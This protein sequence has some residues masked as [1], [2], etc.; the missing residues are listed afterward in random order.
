MVFLSVVRVDDV[1]DVGLS[2]VPDLLFFSEPIVDPDLVD[3]LSSVTLERPA[4]GPVLGLV[5]EAAGPVVAGALEVGADL[6]AGVDLVVDLTFGWT[7]LTATSLAAD[8]GLAPIEDFLGEFVVGP[9]LDPL[10]SVLTFSSF[11]SFSFLSRG[12]GDLSLTGVAGG[13]F[14]LGMTRLA[15]TRSEVPTLSPVSTDVSCSGENSA[16]FSP[17]V[18]PGVFNMNPTSSLASKDTLS[19][20]PLT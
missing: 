5:R 20:S 14:T 3:L 13:T 4:M 6:A 9:E 17:P 18:S 7:C 15:L 2:V 16:S 12:A 1:F 19:A 11:A 10:A 8:L